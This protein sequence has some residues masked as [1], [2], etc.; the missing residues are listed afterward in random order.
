MWACWPGARAR[1]L[2]AVLDLAARVKAAPDGVQLG[3]GPWDPLL[4]FGR[5]VKA[6]IDSRWNSHISVGKTVLD[7][8][9]LP[10]LGVPRLDDTPSL[11]DLIDTTTNPA[12]PPPA[13]GSTI[14]QPIPPPPHPDPHAGA[15]AANGHLGRRRPSDPAGRL[16]HA[17]TKRPASQLRHRDANPHLPTTPWVQDPPRTIRSATPGGYRRRG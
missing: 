4:I 15:T 10:A 5:P 12:P 16:R 14:T 7:L 11:A 13:Y 6:G 17:P 3:Y 2:G 1:I 8:L 9:G